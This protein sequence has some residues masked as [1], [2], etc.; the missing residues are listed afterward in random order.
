MNKQ[1]EGFY[2][3]KTNCVYACTLALFCPGWL[4]RL[5]L[6]HISECEDGIIPAHEI[7]RMKLAPKDELLFWPY[8]QETPPTKAWGSVA[9]RY[10]SN[11]TAVKIL[12]DMKEAVR[13]TGEQ[14][15][16][17]QFYEHFCKI[18]K[19]NLSF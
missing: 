15:H 2:Y 12:F 7:Y 16:A 13:G 17:E 6:I 4:H 18:N 14:E 11:I 19:L 1:K 9:F 3:E 8:L 10:L 5:S